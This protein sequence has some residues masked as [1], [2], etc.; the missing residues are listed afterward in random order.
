[1]MYIKK[2]YNAIVVLLYTGLRISELCGL[3]TSDIDFEKGFIQV[4]HQINY[5]KGKYS[6]NETK[7]ESGIREIPMIKIVKRSIAR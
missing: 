1:M 2:Y 3:T 6:I 5:D 7:T 4:N